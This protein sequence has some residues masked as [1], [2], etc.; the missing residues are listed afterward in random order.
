[1]GSQGVLSSALVAVERRMLFVFLA[2]VCAFFAVSASVASAA[3]VE[4]GSF[5]GGGP[6]PGGSGS[7]NGQ[8]SNPGQV[9]VN[10]ASGEIYVADTGNDRVQIFSPTATGG[11]YD[12]QAAVPGAVGL[13]IDQA[14]GDVYV[15]TG[16]GVSKFDA[17]L[18][19]VASGW[20]DPGVSGPLAVDPSTGD[21]LVAD[22]AGNL[23][24][25]F[26]SDG[27]A[28]GTFAAARPVD[29]AADSTGDVLVITSTGEVVTECAATSTVRRFSGAGV[30]EGQVGASL[31]APGAVAV[32]PD[33]D[34]VVVASRVNQWHCGAE[35][36]LISFFAADSSP[37]EQIALAPNTIYAMVPGLAAQGDGSSRVY[38]VTRS[39]YPDEFGATKVTAL[40]VPPPTPPEVLGQSVLRG[41]ETATLQATI[42]PGGDPT[43]YHFEYG[44]TTAYGQSTAEGS[45][46]ASFDPSYVKAQIS[47]LMPGTTY[48]FRVVAENSIDR[49]EAP[50]RTFTTS[51]VVAGNCP[52]EA[53]RTGAS[54]HLT[55]CRAWE[56]VTPIDS[57][58]NIHVTGGPVTP[59]GDV[60]CFNTEDPLVG[61]DPNGIKIADDG[62]C[63]WRS[64]SGWETKWV[65]GPAP[66]DRHATAQG[67]NVYFLSEDGKRVVFA[68]DAVIFGGDWMPVT[69]DSRGAEISSYMWDEGETTWLAPPGI[70]IGDPPA[71]APEPGY[72]SPG[73]KPL[74]ASADLTRGLFMSQMRIVPEDENELIDLY[75]WHPGGVRLVSADSSGKAVGGA[76]GIQATSFPEGLPP[77]FGNFDQ[78][79]APPGAMSADGSRIFFQ[80]GGEPLD[81]NAGEA[82]EGDDPEDPSPAGILQSVYMREGD[83]VTLVS[84]RR[85]SGPDRSVWFVG[86]TSNGSL[87]Y[88]ETT[89]QL[90][91]EP[92]QSGRAI[93][94]YDVGTD[95]LELVA[96]APGG[97]KFLTLSPDGSTI[98]Y[99]QRL[100]KT[101]I[102]E[103][104]GVATSL[105]TLSDS[106]LEVEQGAA[107]PRQD[108]RMLRV[109]ADGR[110]VVFA[111]S[112]EF[113]GFGPGPKQVYRWETGEGLARIS[114]VEGGSPVSD[115]SIGA[116]SAGIGKAREE[117]FANHNAR[118]N[119][120]RVMSD[121][122]SRVFFE[123]PEQLVERDV[124]GATDV[125]EWHDGE[126]NIVSAGT[127]GNSFYHGNSADGRTV[128]ITTFDRLLPESDRNAKR[129]VYVARPN[130]GFPP[131]APPPACEGEAC[132]PDREAPSAIA[133][134]KGPSEGNLRRGLV[135]ATLAAKGKA[136]RVKVLVPGRVT[137]TLSGSLG[138]GK[139][140]IAAKASR[141]ARNAGTLTLPVKLNR[142]ARALLTERGRLRL[143]LTITH[144]QSDQTITRK[145]TLHG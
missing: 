96:D 48:H 8:L 44:T 19:P 133:A 123:T 52:N 110:V 3:Y 42:D 81:G 41:T 7:D 73:R 33:D 62:F 125:Y 87:A 85:G 83:E 113:G 24:R 109:S 98:V 144:V 53:F 122:G 105:G 69:G 74:A 72:L 28:D 108:K 58:A 12:S 50:D 16:T 117:L 1:M 29:L 11:Q 141:V 35:A 65:T 47:G 10:D 103:R 18:T 59:D 111:A 27:S 127:G 92:K 116:Y 75:E 130:G 118:T 37:L 38:A 21:L 138:N 68:S 57:Q 46:P 131:P 36:P 80:H 63:A 32:D 89:Q 94:R 55:D 95:E 76:A 31:N 121:D 70:G 25:R 97:V 71:P 51:E 15:A 77:D 93:Y 9:D 115:A 145:V 79:V 137:A 20:T 43:T 106:D 64:A 6:G 39:P 112:G 128:F 56:L 17:S 140:F 132:Q 129:D 90:T 45:L 114:S 143:T 136:I 26:N 54:A 107:H 142:K 13:A 100:T 2:A 40:E 22:T 102:V 91:P 84:P 34:S 60:V 99:T 67:G 135:K 86:A 124:N 14:T 61:S 4:A 23:V 49:V 78:Q 120:G 5:A 82:P 134:A 126:I 30:E 104:D 101:L 119:S 66:V 139:K 88:L